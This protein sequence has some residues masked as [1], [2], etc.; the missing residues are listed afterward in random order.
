M[1]FLKD[2]FF[3]SIRRIL[4]ARVLPFI[5]GHATPDRIVFQQDG[6]PA[7]HAQVNT[8][9]LQQNIPLVCSRDCDQ[10]F[11]QGLPNQFLLEWPP[12]SM[13]M[14]PMDF[15]NLFLNM[16]SIFHYSSFNFVHFGFWNFFGQNYSWPYVLL[17]GTSCTH[18]KSCWLRVHFQLFAWFGQTLFVR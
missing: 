5:Q 9:W 1:K 13:D 3:F 10:N 4:Q 12:Y 8:N 17:Y 14:T 6:A 7:H 15:G 18:L 2:I 16:F 11:N